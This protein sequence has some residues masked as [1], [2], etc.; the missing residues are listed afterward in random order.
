VK[1]AVTINR[2]DGGLNTKV[3]GLLGPANESPDL[4]NVI[5]D[6]AGSVQTRY[7][8]ESVGM[9]SSSTPYIVDCLHSYRYEGG[10]DLLAV[11]S[12]L[13]KWD[14]GTTWDFLT[15]TTN[16]FSGGVR[17]HA[18]N[19]LNYAFFGNGTVSYKWNGT[20]F[21]EWGVPTPTTAAI[22]STTYDSSILA[23]STITDTDYN[24]RVA[25]I[26]STNVESE[27]T[28]V[29]TF[30]VSNT[31][32][33]VLIGLNTPLASAGVNYYS[34]YRND[35][36]LE[37]VT[38]GTAYVVDSHDT[39]TIARDETIGD[40]APNGL[41]IFVF[42]QGRMFGVTE[43]TTDLYYTE[44]NSPEEFTATNLIRVGYGDG[45]LIKSLAIY[46]NG[47]IIGKE[48]GYGNGSIWA[49]YMPSA[50]PDDWSLERLN[51]GY[52]N[53]SPQ[54]MAR[55]GT[56]LMLIN[57]QGIYDLTSIRLGVLDS[58]PISYKI[59]PDIFTLA[60]TYLNRACAVEFK[61]KLWISVPYG[62]AAT[63][64]NRL[65]QYDYVKN[66]SETDDGSWTRFTNFGFNNLS[67]HDGE[68]FGSSDNYVYKIDNGDD[69]VY[70][71]N[72]TAI[73]SYY[74][75]MY[76]HGSDEHRDHT[77]V[78]RYIYV[79]VE[80]TG[81]WNLEVSWQGDYST[82][83]DGYEDVS[84]DPGG[85]EWGSAEWG[86]SVWGTSSTPKT[87]RIPIKVISK[88]IQIKFLTDGLDEHFKVYELSLH[89]TLRGLR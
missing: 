43:G 71:D 67:I 74:R 68:L 70:N 23:G 49:L 7:G 84:L 63:E 14:G 86:L 51:L 28:E 64:N 31:C 8:Y 80:T 4:K 16:A 82:S 10:S 87:Y 77:K 36:L 32:Q 5:F 47:L 41:N 76:I 42:H 62:T 26:N 1:Y 88:A 29:V 73:E 34:V 2:F 56:F 81:A 30:S 38:A 27:A 66:R 78:W 85:A 54:A 61:N 21:T 20:D 60:T 44:V 79:T 13:Y 19:A 37:T 9:V 17:C 40:T 52:G 89:Y 24:Y 65:Y 15:D 57:K 59:E 33:P 3:N 35:Y 48:D 55:F 53:V 46:D 69:D 50:D 45:F 25:Y 72:G 75:T 18:E 39:L 58:V 83:T 6:D 22:T 11:Q 12:S